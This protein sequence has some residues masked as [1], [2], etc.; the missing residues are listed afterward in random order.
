MTAV[1]EAM[2]VILQ[3]S[4]PWLKTVFYLNYQI[5]FYVALYVWEA[6]PSRQRVFASSTLQGGRLIL[7]KQL[8]LIKFYFLLLDFQYF[9]VSS[10]VV[11]ES[12]FFAF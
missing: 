5:S 3:G 7:R 9:F 2:N 4:F 10:P 12:G 8:L 1:E 11:Q 6:L